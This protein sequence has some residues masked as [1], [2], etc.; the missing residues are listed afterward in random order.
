VRPEAPRSLRSVGT[1]ACELCQALLG[2]AAAAV[3]NQRD[4][5]RRR[6]RLA[7]VVTKTAPNVQG[8]PPT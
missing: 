1:C 7:V 3:K 6:R 5:L 2:L 8:G 4:V